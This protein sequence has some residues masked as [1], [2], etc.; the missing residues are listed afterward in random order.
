MFQEG[1]AY[2]PLQCIF[3]GELLLG[4]GDPFEPLVKAFSEVIGVERPPY[5]FRKAV[6]RKK[7]GLTL[8][9]RND[10][11]IALSPSLTECLQ[12]CL[13]FGTVLRL[14]DAISPPA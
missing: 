1:C 13:S 7:V 3:I 6:E 11:W 12:S 9:E 10:P 5:G 8:K 2:G 4:F 14:I